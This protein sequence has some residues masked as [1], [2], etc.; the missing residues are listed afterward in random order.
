[1]TSQT[2]H[3]AIYDTLADWEIGYVMAHINSPEFQ[4]EPGRYQVRT[5]AQT[6][7][8]ITTKGGLRVVPDLTI[9]ALDPAASRML[10]LPGADTAM[11]GGIDRFAA[12]A[13]RFLDAGVPVAAICGATAALARIGLLDALPHTSNALQFLEMTGYKGA[14]HYQD[15]LAVRSGNLITA[16]GIAP[17]AFAAEIFRELD[18]Y[19][20]TTL[21]AWRK[22]YGDHNPE[23]FY[24]LMAEHAA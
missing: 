17:I 24:E 4:K 8:P 19:S 22:L 16:S 21:A 20:D 10:I 12:M 7:E 6:P 11:A 23:G 3:L 9:D 18:L 2:V 13:A 15:Q 5:V 1:M 14:P